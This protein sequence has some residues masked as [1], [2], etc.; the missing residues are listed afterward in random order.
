MKTKLMIMAAALCFAVAGVAKNI[1]TVVLTTN[2]KMFC[3]NCENKI[4]NNIR[5]EKGIKEIDTDIK[6]QAVTIKY[7]ADKTDVA[8]IIKGFKKIDYVATEKDKAADTAKPAAE[9]KGGCCGSA[10]CKCGSGAASA[11]GCCSGKKTA[12]GSTA[13]FKAVQ[14]R[15]GGCAAK[16]KGALEAV[17][18]VESATVDLATKSVAVKYDAKVA[19]I[20]KLKAAFDSIS[21]ASP[22][23][24]P[25]DAK[26][27]YVSFKADQM[28]CG[29][30]AAKVKKNLLA[31][32]GVKDVTVCLGTKVVGIAFDSSKTSKEQ[33]VNDFKKFDY[34]VV[35][36]Y[37]N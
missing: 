5:F 26:V 11:G 3:E 13:Y 4:K 31:D 28:K 29:G 6:N 22:Q 19:D 20:D 35:E 12:D 18:G 9:K 7:D 14:M 25:G 34:N 27:Q 16:V 8:A 23:Y 33:I 36:V 24:Y 32:A 37:N 30:C 10:G 21:Y 15:C 2:P 17:P 1:K